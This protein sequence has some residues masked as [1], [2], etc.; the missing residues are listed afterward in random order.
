MVRISF[1]NDV[2]ALTVL[3]MICTSS[4]SDK[5]CI[6]AIQFTSREGLELDIEQNLEKWI[7]MLTDVFHSFLLEENYHKY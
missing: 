1:Q 6:Q 7:T 2:E 5:N 4:F 3:Q